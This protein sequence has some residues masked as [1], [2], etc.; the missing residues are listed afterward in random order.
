[1]TTPAE[2]FEYVPD[3]IEIQPQMDAKARVL[4]DDPAMTPTLF[5]T[6]MNAYYASLNASGTEIL[7]N[8]NANNTYVHIFKPGSLVVQLEGW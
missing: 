5:F 6:E 1:M 4:I 7:P 2:Q 3:Y 8:N